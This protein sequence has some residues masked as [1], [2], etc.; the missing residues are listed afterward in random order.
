MDI[1]E[2]T[3][4]L[5]RQRRLLLIGFIGLGIAVFALVFEVTRDSDGWSIENRIPPKYE[6]AIE[7]VVVPEGLDSLASRGVS[8]GFAGPAQ[9]YAQLLSTPEAARQIEEAQGIELLDTLAADTPSDTSFITVT[10]TSDT[11]EGAVTGAMGAFRWLEGR[12]AEAPVMAQLPE[13]DPAVVQEP[14]LGSLLVNMDRL[15]ANADPGLTLVI[16]NFQGDEVAVSVQAAAGGLEP[17]L[18]HVKPDG[19]ITVSVEREVGVP[20]DTE[21]IDVPPLLDTEVARP[22]LVLS[23]EW[24]GID[25]EEVE[26][27]EDAAELDEEELEEAEALALSEAG[28]QLDASRISVRWDTPATGQEERISVMLI[29]RELTVKE[30]GERRTPVMSLALLGVGT[31]ALLVLTTT[32]D[33]WQ[34]AREERRAVGHEEAG[35]RELTEQG[36]YLARADRGISLQPPEPPVP[37]VGE[38]GGTHGHRSSRP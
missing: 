17:Q 37:E 30:T 20:L 24:G 28:A 14:F 36:L 7:M 10:A 18:A 15:Y 34:R 29:T 26:P 19:Q 3:R 11:P 4:A 2:F 23:I 9:V 12:L 8:G 13:P 38:P 16:T 5:R 32:V 35:M 33:T 21:T 1:Y 25:F 31:L 22:P 27:V 6:S